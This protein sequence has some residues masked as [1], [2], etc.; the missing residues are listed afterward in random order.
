MCT[1]VCKC[2]C[3]GVVSAR[4]MLAGFI[5]HNSVCG[6]THL[7]ACVIFNVTVRYILLSYTHVYWWLGSS[8]GI[9]TDYRLDG[10]G[11][12]PGGDKIF[13]LSRPAVGP[14]Q[15]PVQWVP[16]LSWG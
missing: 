14:T 8:I 5:Y 6:V 13:C 1:C 16:G 7:L 4:M 9:A 11:S 10:P 3:T 15:P 2:K 12:N